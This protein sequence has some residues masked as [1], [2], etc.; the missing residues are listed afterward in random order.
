MHE[1]RSDGEWDC[2]GRDFR[3]FQTGEI[4]QPADRGVV[5]TTRRVETGRYKGR[6]SP[7]ILSGV[8]APAGSLRHEGWFDFT[9][10]RSGLRNHWRDYGRYS[11][12]GRKRQTSRRD[13]VETWKKKFSPAENG[14]LNS[15][16]DAILPTLPRHFSVG[17]STL[18]IYPRGPSGTRVKYAF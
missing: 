12:Y 4:R 17:H 2:R 13:A 11:R 9:S 7:C 15:C 5:A 18:M 6:E 10:A 16:C 1:G 14:K 3:S 8:S